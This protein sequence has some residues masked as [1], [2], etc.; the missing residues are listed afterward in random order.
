MNWILLTDF[1]RCL[2]IGIVL[3]LTV[4]FYQARHENRNVAIFVS[5]SL[6]VVA[7]LLI[8]LP[9]IFDSTFGRLLLSGPFLL[10]FLFWVLSQALFVDGF[11]VKK[12]HFA[13]G[14]VV[15]LIFYGVFFLKRMMPA[16]SGAFALAFGLLTQVIS[17]TFAIWAAFIAYSGRDSDL[18][19]ARIRFRKVFVL[20]TAVTIGITLLSEIIIFPGESPPV[21]EFL[22]KLGI[23]ILTFF[24][25]AS[26]L[27][28][29]DGFLIRRP[30]PESPVEEIDP[31]L[32]S[33]LNQLLAV[34]K[35]YRKEGLTIGQLADAMRSKEYKLRRLINQQLG[36]R[37]FNDF[38]NQHRIQ[39]A[40][41]L[42]L[43]PQQADLTI[44]EIAYQIGYT[45][46]GPFNS[47]F[48]RQTGLTPTQYR[49][50]HQ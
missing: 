14:F 47:A 1:L 28:F 35:I 42:L 9:G 32:H 39:E 13:M 46:L 45:S 30:E 2:T 12:K 27:T 37:N 31:V 21:L 19:E 43:D 17:L 23:A 10:P 6:A 22:Q 44:L 50:T 5:F 40:C 48:K 41:E 3:T 16:S 20:I 25:A 33:Q 24:V 18:V 38:L 15:L 36:F 26:A 49:K 4:A 34:E 29:S 11:R 7:Y 8:G